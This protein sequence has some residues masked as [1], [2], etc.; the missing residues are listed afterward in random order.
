MPKQI[1]L[2][3][4]MFHTLPKTNGHW[5]KG[6]RIR[7]NAGFLYIFSNI[8]M[9]KRVFLYRTRLMQVVIP[10]R[11]V[12]NLKVCT[13][14]L[15]KNSVA[16]R[17]LFWYFYWNNI[18]LTTPSH[19]DSGKFTTVNFTCVLKINLKSLSEDKEN[20]F[21]KLLFFLIRIFH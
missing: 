2:L 15:L 1:I 17:F 4:L 19:Q 13:K 20:N 10:Y 18:F 7:Q 9:V 21:F 11:I 3:I 8:S 16:L 6:L 5:M 12:F 14:F